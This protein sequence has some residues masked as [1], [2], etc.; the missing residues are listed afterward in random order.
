MNVKLNNQ[1]LKKGSPYIVLEAGPTHEGLESAKRLA[2]MAK[3]AGGDSIKFQWI[4]T[5]RLM[6]D[7]G[8]QFG[9]SYLNINSN[10]DEEFIPVKEPL[11]DILKR[12]ELNKNEWKELKSYCDSIGIHMFLT[13]CYKD[14]IDFIVDELKIDS[15][16]INSSD[17]GEEDLIRYAATKKVNIQ[18]DTGN[19]NLWEIE[20]AVNIITEEGND[21]IIIHHCPSGYPAKL[22]SIHL[23]MIPTLQQLFPNLIIAFS[24][25]SPG[26]EM[27]IAAIALGA[28]MI[29]K[30]IT[31]D[32]TI[33]S[34]E[35]SF[36]LERED[37]VQ[38]VTSIRELEVA[39][40]S[41][42]RTIPQEVQK[43][44]KVSR[45]SPYALSDLNVGE[46]IEMEKIEMKRPCV[47]LNFSEL[48]AYTGL[49]LT[50]P[51]QKGEVLSKAHFE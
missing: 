12:R 22:D 48:N 7:K 19:S 37:A 26:W 9:Y 44:R 21:N 6:A 46:V 11:Y 36:S 39:L 31:E 49:K 3:E 4:D 42:R 10:G 43:S 35:H 45:R 34:C 13:A 25:H 5:D 40:G 27:D 17:I 24:D 47:G 30:T 8:I 32:R 15:I 51:L 38:F 14:E 16:K 33:K 18:L 2:L 41:A 50:K 1:I 28:V 29:E 23:N 20:K